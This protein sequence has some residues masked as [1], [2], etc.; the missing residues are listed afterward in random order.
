MQKYLLLILLFTLILPV[1]SQENNDGDRFIRCQNI[2]SEL[3]LQTA[4]QQYISCSYEQDCLGQLIVSTLQQCWAKNLNYCEERSTLYAIAI[5]DGKNFYNL[6]GDVDPLLTSVSAF[7]AGDY[8]AA[9]KAIESAM[10]TNPERYFPFYTH[11]LA[12]GIIHSAS[13]N[14][15][16]AL[17][18]YNEAINIHFFS[19]LTFYFRGRLYESMGNTDH[20]YRDYYTYNELA[21]SYLKS[22][23]PLD[24]FTYS[25]PEAENWMAYPVLSRGDGIVAI[26]IEDLTLQPN[27]LAQIAILDN[28]RTLAVSNFSTEILFMY[29]NF[30]SPNILFL[31]QNEVDSQRYTLTM[32]YQD[33]PSSTALEFHMRIFPHYAEYIETTSFFEGEG[34][35]SGVLFPSGEPD[36][37]LN[38]DNRPCAGLA[39]SHIQLG[40]EVVGNYVDGDGFWIM[41]TEPT[42]DSDRVFENPQAYFEKRTNSEQFIVQDGP[43]CSDDAIWW[44]IASGEIEGWMP[45]SYKTSYFMMPFELREAWWQ[46][47]NRF[48]SPAESLGLNDEPPP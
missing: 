38:I 30:A 34:V 46:L 10:T 45:E 17:Q 6:S 19:P 24:Y 27:F 11:Y 42:D 37:R 29:P 22:V 20:A 16:L 31:E 35:T 26:S 18:N 15:E 47:P 4:C 39:I 36:P 32:I 5:T 9:A 44:R 14:H 33:H 1:N 48:P 8:A 13:G 21:S 7:D 12:L 2:T 41:K 28:G 43:V 23:L 25:L 3:N 40:D